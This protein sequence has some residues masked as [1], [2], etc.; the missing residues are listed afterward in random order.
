MIGTGTKIHQHQSYFHKVLEMKLYSSF[1]WTS[2]TNF[3]IYCSS[4]SM[5][6]KLP[7]K[8]WNNDDAFTKKN[9]IS[10]YI[11]KRLMMM[12]LLIQ[13]ARLDPFF[14]GLLSLVECYFKCLLSSF[15]WCCFIFFIFI[16]RCII[17]FI[18]CFLIFRNYISFCQFL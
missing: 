11:V 15:L 14:Q 13:G 7:R 2:E 9:Y 3:I 10:I 18:V 4:R 16:T 8:R 12:T 6:R 1:G 17:I 5:S